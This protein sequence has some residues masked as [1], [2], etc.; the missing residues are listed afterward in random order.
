[1]SN[2]VEHE[3]E[4]EQ[5]S[6]SELGEEEQK[7][8]DHGGAQQGFVSLTQARRRLDFDGPGMA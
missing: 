4:L 2:L 8:L 1:M 6:E 5:L 7:E 3:L